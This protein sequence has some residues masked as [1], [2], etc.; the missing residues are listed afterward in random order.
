MECH[1]SH[2][3]EIS[4]L[5]YRTP[6]CRHN[7]TRIANGQT[8]RVEAEVLEFLDAGSTPAVSIHMKPLSFIECQKPCY[9]KGFGTFLFH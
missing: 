1:L 5:A 4:R 6:V 9:I 2:R 3:Q 7:A 8:T